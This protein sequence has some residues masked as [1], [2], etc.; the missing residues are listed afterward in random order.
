[1]GTEF[2]LTQMEDRIKDTGK[3]ENNMEKEFSLL[4]KVLRDKESGMKAN[5]RGGLM[6]MNN[7]KRW[8]YHDVN[9]LYT[10]KNNYLS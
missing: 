10:K 7:K 6:R 5:A 4:P 9:V 1:M 3:M 8:K 2:T